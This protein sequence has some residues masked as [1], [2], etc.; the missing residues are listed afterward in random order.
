VISD[1]FA[2]WTDAP[3]TSIPIGSIGTTTGS[4]AINSNDNQNLICF[5]CTPSGG[6]GKD[7]IAITVTSFDNAGNLV[8][9]DMA[10]NTNTQ[11]ITDPV[12]AQDPVESLQT[13][14]THE[15]GHFLGLDHTAVVRAVMNPFAPSLLLTLS[16]DDVAGVSTNYPAPGFSP[17]SISGTV[18]D[19]NNS[20]VFGA[21]V[22][23]ESTTTLTPLTGVRKS[24]ISAITDSA[25]RYTISGVPQDQYTVTAEPLN[26]PVNNT[27]FTGSPAFAT[28]FTTRQH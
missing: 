6:F 7:A 16:Y 5:V 2:K 12:A 18:V 24:P 1:A 26:D 27:N 9:A 21:H 15:F 8:D 19:G 20:P 22:F 13:V 3:N 11:F 10:F 4:T 23:A 17:L 25:G 28:T 14:A